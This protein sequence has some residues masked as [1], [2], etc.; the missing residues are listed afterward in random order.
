ME[1]L[2]TVLI[3][4]LVMAL[5]IYLVNAYLPIDPRIKTIIN[6]VIVLLVII[7]LLQVAGL[8]GG[9]VSVD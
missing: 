2:V 7:Y 1:M 9:S 6:G 8:L 3:V 4:L 5:A